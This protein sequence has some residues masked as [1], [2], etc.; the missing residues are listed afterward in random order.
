MEEEKNTVTVEDSSSATTSKLK[1]NYPQ[2]LKVGIAFGLISLFWG[3]YDFVIPLLLENAYG[4]SNTIR[5]LIMGLDN[6]LSLFLL[7]IMGRLSDKSK[8][9]L[10]SRYGRRTPFILLGTVAAVVFMVF[11]PLSAKKQMDASAETR[12]Y[13]ESMLNDDAFMSETLSDFWDSNNA[14]KYVDKDYIKNSLEKEGKPVDQSSL[15]EFFI[16]IRY[17]GKFESKSGFLGIGGTSYFYD[18]NPLTLNNDG[19]L[20]DSAGSLTNAEGKEYSAIKENNKY[21]TSF[22]EAGMTVM[23]SEKVQE[24]TF[25]SRQGTSSIALYMILLLFTLIAM[26]TFR[27][28]AVALMPDVTPKPLRS[29][30]NAVINLCGGI[31]GGLAL[32]VYT[33]ILMFEPITSTHYILI[34]AICGV[35]MLALLGLFLWLVKERKLVD[36]CRQQC[37]EFGISDED[38]EREA[39]EAEKQAEAA[40]AFKESEAETT[41]KKTKKD[42]TKDSFRYKL[43]KFYYDKNL[44]ERAKFRSFILILASIFMWFIGYNAVSSSLSVYC[45]KALLLSP[46]TASIINAASM[47]ISAVAFIPVGFLAVKI[48]RKKSI[49]IGF[50]LAVISY[51]LLLLVLNPGEKEIIK[52]IVFA[53]FYLIS[54]FGLIIANVNT[55][56]MVVELAKTEDVGKYTG[57][58]YT[59]TMSAQAITPFLAGL[60][61]DGW[62]MKYL[63]AYAGVAVAI[64]ILLMLFVKHGDSKQLSSLKKMTKE[65]KKQVMLDSMGDAD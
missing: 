4:L 19:K 20:E 40:L 30:A 31:G 22:A 61:M 11:V 13:Y 52:A 64:A 49:M 29:Q 15:K 28:P 45:T 57:Y 10:V 60:V 59:A 37:E 65:E 50:G 41:G 25:N 16:S 38:E 35:L 7:P 55:F 9:K 56:P 6:L 53:S 33:V 27:S 43:F 58:Y 3:A 36:K 24:A 54:G 51:I 23:I 17:D 44:A 32:I 39:K 48:G 34:F 47:A 5:G 46:G 62:G 18:G 12:A 63:F 42:P 2:T 14:S 8:G 21:Y 26:A 1:L